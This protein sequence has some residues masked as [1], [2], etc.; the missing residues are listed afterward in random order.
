ML[1]CFL[2]VSLRRLVA[3]AC[4]LF[5]HSRRFEVPPKK[6][7]YLETTLEVLFICTLWPDFQ[8]KVPD[9]LI[10]PSWT[11]QTIH[12]LA[13][14]SGNIS[15][16]YTEQKTIL[17]GEFSPN[18]WPTQL[19]AMGKCL[20]QQG[21]CN[22]FWLLSNSRQTKSLVCIRRRVFEVHRFGVRKELGYI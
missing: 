12:L 4:Y 16:C 5:D 10:M 13:E 17:L 3:S 8:A 19:R 14:W 22:T 20:R 15:R 9:M 21:F 6:S 18:S 7:N 1:C 2:G 11:L